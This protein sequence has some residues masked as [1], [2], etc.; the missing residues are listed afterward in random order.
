MATNK[1]SN[2]QYL[3]DFQ[4]DTANLFA[5]K[6][7]FIENENCRLLR[8]SGTEHHLIQGAM[9]NLKVL[10]NKAGSGEVEHMLD[11]RL[12]DLKINK[13]NFEFNELHQSVLQSAFIL[14]NATLEF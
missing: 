4:T 1:T 3:F 8:L 5:S 10:N 6:I 13:C 2:R 14:H 11:F 7:S 12:V 9:Q